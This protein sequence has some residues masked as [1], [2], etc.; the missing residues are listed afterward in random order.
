MKVDI[1]AEEEA[2]RLDQTPKFPKD[3][4]E[5]EIIVEMPVSRELEERSEM[6]VVA[7]VPNIVYF[8]NI[9]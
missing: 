3:A 5:H 1:A 8:G 4:S 7:H 9:M 2:V 6:I